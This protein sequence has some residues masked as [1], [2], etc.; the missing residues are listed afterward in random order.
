MSKS[1]QPRYLSG[2]A[3]KRAR[4]N[5]GLEQAQLAGRVGATQG[6][7]SGW[8]RGQTGC[9]IGML[10][11]LATALG[12]EPAALMLDQADDDEAEPEDAAAA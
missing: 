6:Q 8:E 9:R 5:A 1:V 3:L 11:K 2:D 4:L 7:V 12:C 10:H